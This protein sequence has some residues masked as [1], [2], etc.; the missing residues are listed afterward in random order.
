MAKDAN[1]YFPKPLQGK[2]IGKGQWELTSPFEY[3]TGGNLTIKIPEGFITDGASIPKFAYSII[4]SPWTGKYAKISVV[5]DF[6]YKKHLYPRKVSDKI[7]LNGMK[8]L[9]VSWWRR[10]IMYTAVRLGGRFCW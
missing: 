6:L 9:G 2:F 4:G 5:H 10:R 3:R 8:I 1:K 7:F